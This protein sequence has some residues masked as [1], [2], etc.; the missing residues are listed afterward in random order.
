MLP[1]PQTGI[2]CFKALRKETKNIFNKSVLL[3]IRYFLIDKCLGGCPWMTSHNFE[4]LSRFMT[5]V[6]KWCDCDVTRNEILL[7]KDIL[8]NRTRQEKN[9]QN[10]TQLRFPFLWL[11][12]VKWENFNDLL[13]GVPFGFFKKAKAVW[14]GLLNLFARNIMIW[15]FMNVKENRIFYGIFW[16]NLNKKTDI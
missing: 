3:V 15:P 10:W 13:P 2:L 4:Q 8:L 9:C 1:F 11:S 7:K 16:Q 6:K 14:F 12:R 5:E